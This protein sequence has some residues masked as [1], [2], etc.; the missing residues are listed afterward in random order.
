MGSSSS[1]DDDAG[2]A[3]A[4]FWESFVDS[5]RIVIDRNSMEGVRLTIVLEKGVEN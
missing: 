3:G 1:S 5:R 4:T 2:S